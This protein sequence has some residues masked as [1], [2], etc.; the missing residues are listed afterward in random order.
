MAKGTLMVNLERDWF[1]PNGSLYQVRDNPHE[2]PASW[3]DQIPRIK[4]PVRETTATGKLPAVPEQAYEVDEEARDRIILGKDAKTVAVV[5]NTA[6]GSVIV[7]TAVG[8]EVKSV[9]GA[10]DSKGIEQPAQSV[11]SAAAGAKE[12]NLEVGG[13]P[14]ESGPLPAGT[15][16]PN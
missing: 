7:A 15:K 13:K 4:K 10:L 11:A 12:Q 2:F 6:S 5:Q 16:K 3:E 14:R 1:A 8:D 9:G